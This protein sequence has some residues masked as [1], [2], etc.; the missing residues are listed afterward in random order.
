[1]ALNLNRPKIARNIVLTAMI[2]ALL[3]VIN[4]FLPLTLALNTLQTKIRTKPVSGDVV[5]V[6]IDAATIDEIGRWPWTRDVQAKLLQKID[7]YYPKEVYIDLGYSGKTDAV[8]DRALSET[9]NG[10]KTP[11]TVAA[12]GAK[13]DDGVVEIVYSHPAAIGNAAS[14]TV[15]TPS[16]FGFVWSF[17]IAVDTNRGLIR[18]FS[19]SIAKLH[20]SSEDTFRIDYS[21]DPSSVTIIAAKE[22]FSGNVPPEKLRGKVVIIGVTDLDQRD[23]HFMP[24][25]GSRAGVLFHVLGAETL[26]AGVPTDLGWLPFFLFALV[27]GAAHLTS[28]GLRY[29][30]VL[31]LSGVVGIL[32]VSSWFTTMHLVNDPF[33]AV[34]FM[35]SVAIYVGRQKR[36]LMRSQRDEQTGFA[37]MTGYHVKEVTSNALIVGA[38][39]ERA[40][41]RLGQ[42]LAGDDAKIMRE[43][44]RRLSTVIDE[45]QLTHNT[46]EQFLWEMP[47]FNSRDIAEHL[48]GLRRLFSAPIIID[49]RT[50]DVDI[51]FGVD[52]DV[53]ASVKTRTA[54]ALEASV[55]A[56]DSNATL[57]IATSSS[58]EA[59]LT[60]NFGSEFEAAIANGEVDIVLEA[61]HALAGGRIA[62]AEATLLWQHPSYGELRGSKILDLAKVS[63]QL[64]K[65][66]LYL[67]DRA[68]DAAQQIN[69]I[70]PGFTISVEA[71]I[72]VIVDEKFQK[73]M[74]S[75]KKQS[76]FYPSN[77][78]VTVADIQRHIG[79]HG[80][81]PAIGRI[82]DGGFR[83]GISNFGETNADIDL[84]RQ[85][86][87]DE[88]FFSERFYEELF[89]TTS[90]RLFADAA[91]RIA[92]VANIKTTAQGVNDRS[93]LVEM[94]QRGC[95]RAQGKILSN[96]M[97][98]KEF[99]TNIGIEKARKTG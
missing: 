53:N 23:Y 85:F 34:A 22:I 1:M 80:C 6:G 43:V 25:W 51:F 62:S 70:L 28:K 61:Q 92:R 65:V 11:V 84:I 35:V 50:I 88:I 13:S 78:V 67:C 20:T 47:M 63:G 94:T 7:G 52:R 37:D 44:G 16:L 33:P 31:A 9:L 38:K 36:A 2:C 46:A 73:W 3:G 87:P 81:K 55:L 5:I 82:K 98:I 56:R 68:G 54:R 77:I 29:Y 40:Y 48:D 45:R 90:S 4:F 14:G 42:I 10:L 72:D 27:I 15:Y 41:M 12:F 76:K 96:Y 91:L 60:K 97:N 49:N 19:A 8:A 86:D 95:E 75:A 26:K 89:G 21:F 71:G 93:V 64:V 99:I 58:F 66:I 17:P 57:K 24:G 32:A 69:S 83:L 18:S 39:V 59:H 74:D 30:A 79:N